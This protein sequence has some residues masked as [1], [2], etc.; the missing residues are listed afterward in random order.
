MRTGTPQFVGERLREARDVRGLTAHSLSQLIGVSRQAVSQYEN[1]PETPSPAVLRR[2]ADVLRLPLHY[3]LQPVDTG[4]D[5]TFFYR[6]MA[7]ATKASRIRAESRFKWTQRIV[8]FIRVFVNLPQVNYPVIRLPA[9]PLEIKHADIEEAA[10]AAR[11]HWRLGDGPISNV[12]LLLENNGTVIVRHDLG[13]ETLDA[14]SMWSNAEQ[15][16]Y[17]VLNSEKNVAVR[18]RF[19]IAHELGHLIIHKNIPPGCLN[20]PELF[21]LIEQQAHSFASA[22][23]LPA[24]TFVSD[25]AA[26]TLDA[27]RALKAKWRV[28]IQTMIFR[29]K[30][31]NLLSPDQER[32]LW[33]NL[34]RR[35][36][37]TSEPLDD[38]LEPEMP[39]L[40]PRSIELMVKGGVTTCQDIVFQNA[41]PA[42]DIEELTG[43]PRGYLSGLQSSDSPNGEPAIIRFPRSG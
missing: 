41:L 3:F 40:L 10:T 34:A 24:K 32:R 30:D 43:L 12:V 17:V 18:S 42:E 20:R 35:G 25:M 38:I 14:F 28:S 11:R 4:M 31:L 8:R 33:P 19:D 6:S 36:W 2:M 15:S 39:R 7:A 13:A 21:E 1:G 5:G 26:P 16:P 9:D 23:L 37:R 27:F 29:A 22:F